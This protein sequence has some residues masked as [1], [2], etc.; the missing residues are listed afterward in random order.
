MIQTVSLY[1]VACIYKWGNISGFLAAFKPRKVA[2]YL[3]TPAALGMVI[4]FLLTLSWNQIRGELLWKQGQDLAWAGN[5]EQS[6]MLYREAVIYLP[7]NLE[8]DFYL[9]AA[10]SK[11]GQA[12]KAIKYLTQSQNGFSDKNQYIALGKTYTDNGDYELAEAA[13]SKVLY[14]YPALLSPYFWLSRVYY[15]QGDIDRAKQ[16]L[17]TILSAENILNSPEIERVKMDARQ[18][19]DYMNSW[20]AR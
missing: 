8:L 11:T 20:E 7:Y 9:G 18:T 2:L 1:Q 10:Y 14:Y 19:L 17:E 16:E 4:L 6:I 13:L 3:F 12:E 15:E 5:W